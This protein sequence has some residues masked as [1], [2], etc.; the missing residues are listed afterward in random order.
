MSL[1]IRLVPLALFAVALLAHADTPA[2]RQAELEKQVRQLEKEIEKVRGLKFKKPVTAK[3]IPRPKDGRPGIQGYYDT[4]E[5]AL[6]LYDDVKSNYWKGTLVHEMV[7]ALQDQHFGLRKLHAASFGSDGELALAALVEGDATFTMIELLGKEQP[8]VTKMLATDLSKARNLQNAFLYGQGAK[9]VQAVKAKG[10]WS[11]VDARYNFPPTATAVILHPGE[12]IARV[13]LGPGKSIGE[14]GLIELLR[15]Q[16]ATAGQAV[17]AAAGWAGDRQIEE[18]GAK[19]W[20]VAFAQPAQAARFQRALVALRSAE[21]P[22]QKTVA[23]DATTQT[24]HG[25]KG[26]RRTVTLRGSRV[27]EI[28]APDARAHKAML[29]RLEGP[30][31]L[32]IFQAA[33]KRQLS[34]GE[35]TDRLLE[36]DLLCVG[37]THDSEVDHAVQLM[38][39]KALFARDERLGVGMEMFQR[40]YQKAVDRYLSGATDEATFL[41]DTEYRTRWGYEWGLYR[42]IVSFCKHNRIPLAALNVADELRKRISRV[43][44]EKLNAD[45]KKQLGEVDFQVKEH[46]K[47]WF[48]QLGEMHGHGEMT[49]EGK[50]KFYQVMT[51]WDE[52]MA[53]SAARFQKE[54][55]LR[56]LVVL[57]GSGH[58]ERGFGIPQRAAKR[59]GG[60]VLTVR[61]VHGGDVAKVSADPAADFVV[62]VQ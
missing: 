4:K 31:K 1:R 37:E 42:P 60:K 9:W 28:E 29:D 33:D 19:G 54:R 59:S 13:S 6:F 55:Q 43:G 36:A 11:A 48:D 35:F 12:R 14:Y 3:V 22:K 45:E 24:W 62:F 2:A 58:I 53:D 8:H 46:R 52:Y 40:P 10:G 7:H 51:V 47:H 17:E 49:A 39:V 50:E 26:G 34:F 20:I 30:P 21:F 57:A 23:E 41:E 27:W 44:Y 38:I 32:S 15:R 16:P 61:I 56:R 25:D 18:G 5:K